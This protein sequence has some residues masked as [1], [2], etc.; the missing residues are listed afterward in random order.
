MQASVFR[1]SL[2]AINERSGL[3]AML[4][5]IIT[6]RTPRLHPSDCPVT[7]SISPLQRDRNPDHTGNAH[8]QNV[9]VIPSGSV[10]KPCYA[11]LDP[12]FRIVPA[13]CKCNTFPRMF[14]RMPVKSI[15]KV[16]EAGLKAGLPHFIQSE[17]QEAVLSCL[18]CS[19]R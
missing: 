4:T 6:T 10:P 1:A 8:T 19:L 12:H 14:N 18:K 3:T 13:E 15:H 11:I 5:I 16:R 2:S 7:L 17:D 9:K